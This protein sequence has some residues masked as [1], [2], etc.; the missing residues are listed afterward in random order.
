LFDSDEKRLK[1][2][3]LLLMVND[4]DDDDDD[5]YGLLLCVVEVAGH[6]EG[7]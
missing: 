1:C 4:D 2:V 6:C 7:G 5:D 3:L